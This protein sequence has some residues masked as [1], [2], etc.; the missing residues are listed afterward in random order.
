MDFFF[1]TR[2]SRKYLEEESFTFLFIFFFFFGNCFFLFF[3]IKL[4]DFPFLLTNSSLFLSFH[5]CVC[6]CGRLA[7][8]EH[9]EFLLLLSLYGWLA[10]CTNHNINNLDNKE[11]QNQKKKKKKK[12]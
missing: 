6:V 1:L 5:S 10:D 4:I 12:K 8:L 9:K 2:L 7:Y 11:N 3:K